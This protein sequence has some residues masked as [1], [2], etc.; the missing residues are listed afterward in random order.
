[1]AGEIPLRDLRFQVATPLGFTVHVT[2]AYWE[3]IVKVSIQL[4]KDVRTM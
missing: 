1:M 4:W 3:L 2:D